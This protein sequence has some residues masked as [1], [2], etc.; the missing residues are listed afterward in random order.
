MSTTRSKLVAQA[1]SWLGCK[2]S[3][4]S[5][6]QIID[7][8][9]SHKPLA[10]GYK[11]TYAN[12]WCAAF[13]TACA[14]KCGATDIIPK[15]CS[16]SR[17]IELFKSLGG[18]VENDAYVPFPGDIVFYDWQDNGVGDNANGPDHVG[19]VEKV[20]GTTITVIDGNNSNGECVNRRTLKVNGKYIR[21]Y[22]VPKYDKEVVT[23]VATTTGTK[24]NVM[25]TLPIICRGSKGNAVKTLQRLLNALGYTDATEKALVVDGSFGAATLYALKSYQTVKQLEIDGICG[26][27]TW[28]SILA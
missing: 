6:H 4:G 9:N 16:C 23:T 19:I 27:E 12:E 5:H 25:V 21:G 20:V 22:G 2:E 18:W 7:V 24:G 3:N 1:K 14:I 13:V 28:K 17:M 8:Y 15:E 10:R 26:A 11:M